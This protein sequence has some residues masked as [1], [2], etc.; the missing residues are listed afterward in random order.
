MTT[1]DAAR[2]REDRGH[3]AV[4]RGLIRHIHH[5]GPQCHA[6]L[7]GIAADRLGGLGISAADVPHARVDNVFGVREG[8]RRHCAEPA[9]G[10]GD[11]NN[12]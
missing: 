3:R 2:L 7:G 8:A 1:V 9:R 6:V 10:A 4:N 12:L 11:E 5:D